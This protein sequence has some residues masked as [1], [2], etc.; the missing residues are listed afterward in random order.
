MECYHVTVPEGANLTGYTATGRRVH[1]VPGEYWVHAL[2]RR[3]RVASVAD[4]VRFVGADRHGCDVHVPLRSIP[5][6]LDELRKKAMPALP[7][8]IGGRCPRPGPDV[9]GER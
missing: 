1:I 3:G 5:L 4:S 9:R 2:A 6:E 8:E 7:R